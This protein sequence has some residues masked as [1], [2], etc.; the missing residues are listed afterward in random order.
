MIYLTMVFGIFT[1]TFLLLLW[2]YFALVFPLVRL[3]LTYRIE[4]DFDRLRLMALEG[5]IEVGSELFGRLHRFVKLAYFGVQNDSWLVRKKVP[6]SDL[7]ARELRLKALLED[8]ESADP[9]LRQI[10]ARTLDS[11]TGVY[12]AQRPLKIVFNI[13]TLIMRAWA[14]SAKK[15]WTD[16]EVRYTAASLA[17]S[18]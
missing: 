2:M 18:G 15:R 17:P 3:Q 14:D 6:P 10:V 9:E 5:K 1:G 12:L 7:K 11:V 4:R 16:R 8:F 13:W